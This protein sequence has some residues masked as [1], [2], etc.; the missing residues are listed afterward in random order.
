MSLTRLFLGLSVC[1]PRLAYS[2]APGTRLTVDVTVTSIALRG[3]T[4]TVSYTLYNRPTS[5]DSL[6]LFMVD[7]PAH[8][9]SISRPSPD[10]LWSADT[11]LH[12]VQPVAMWGDLGLLAPAATSSALSFESVGLP[13]IQQTWIQ[14]SFPIPT[15]TESDS[16]P[17]PPASFEEFNVIGKTVGIDPWPND[18]SSQALLAR[19]RSLTQTTCDASLQWI[20]NASLCTQMLADLDEA[21]SQRA[22]GSPSAARGA[23]DSFVS[24]LGGPDPANLASGVTT[25]AYWLL[26]PNADIVRAL[27]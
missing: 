24:R 20:S 3:D 4:A 19:V 11:L 14:G 5:Q 2:Q 7:A 13:G 23:I 12:A 9:K 25:S 18:R 26:K 27:L 22:A 10:S 21:E 8:V 16:G 6:L 15:G 17:P 1:L